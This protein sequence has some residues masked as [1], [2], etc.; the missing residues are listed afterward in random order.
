[1]NEL[2]NDADYN[3]CGIY[4]NWI[5]NNDMNGNDSDLIFLLL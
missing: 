2:I 3:Y 1:M 4:I 5:M